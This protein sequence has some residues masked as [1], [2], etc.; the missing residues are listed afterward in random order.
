MRDL[1]D[2]ASKAASQHGLLTARDIF[3]VGTTRQQLREMTE[4]GVLERVRRDVY[5]LAGAP[6][7]WGQAV[8]AATLSA[9]PPVVASHRSALR[10]W[11]LRTVDDVIEVTVRHPASRRI[12]GVVAHR[13]RDLV[14]EDITWIDAIPTTCP[15]RTIGDAGAI[16][17]DHEVQRILDHAVATGLVTAQDLWRF[18]RRVGRQGRNGVGP[19]HRAL[20]ALPA[21]DVG[22]ESGPELALLRLC[23]GRGLRRP[24]VQLPVIAGG[25]RY[26][27]DLAYPAARIALEYDGREAHA[28]RT[29]F[30]DDR[31]RQNDLVLEGWTVLRFSWDDLRH[32]PSQIVHQ[33]REALD[34]ASRSSVRAHRG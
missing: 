2:L 14:P 30:T 7:S 31:R 3:D 20:E 12:E 34:A 6:A 26:R 28:G 23:V 33:I 21:D 25:R 4:K 11:D 27:L 8:L 17:P 10:L 24:V 19:L 1:R 16:L 9:G 5:R 18:R 13:S 22:A 29:R 15:V 32:R